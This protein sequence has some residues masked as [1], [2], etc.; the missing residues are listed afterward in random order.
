MLLVTIQEKKPDPDAPE[1]A[2]TT[3]LGRCAKLEYGS[4]T[5]SSHAWREWIRRNGRLGE[6][7]VE[8]RSSATFLAA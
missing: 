6:R 1:S 4:C 7:E 5:Y 3:R 2:P 8:T